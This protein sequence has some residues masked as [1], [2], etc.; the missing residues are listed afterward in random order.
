VDAR[1]V[2]QRAIA[3]AD[4]LGTLAPASPHLVHMPSHTYS[5]VGRYADA[6]RVNEAAVTA[7]LALFEVQKAQGFTV[8]K[9]WRH[10]NQH[11]LWFAALMEGRG[12]VALQAARDIAERAAKSEST[13]G[14]YRRSLP[15][16]ALMRMQRWE[17]VLAE[18]APASRKG[19]QQAL[20]EQARG[21]AYARTGRLAQAR[22]A[23]AQVEAGGATLA[24][25]HAS[26]NRF[27]VM[28][29]EVA[30]SA[31]DHLRAEIASAEGR[32]DEALKLQARA[33]AAS[34]KADD[35]EPPMLAAGAR[36]ALG[37]LQLRAGRAALAEATYR[38]DL[39]AQP[40]SG[41]AL[42]GL[43]RALQAQGKTAEAD[44]LKP[45]LEAAW[46]LADAGLKAAR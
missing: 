2:A 40:G 22:T 33:L 37:D 23:L 24:K 15:V 3:A 17:A 30:Q 18:P 32:H 34:A 8:S 5:Q 6:T 7:E 43:T 14:E 26:A 41:W 16:L 31:A 45:Q 28:L 36:V 39:A 35:N 20:T 25:A 42:N 10:H 19:L 12:D 9:D 29:R 27:D 11:F 4:R 21:V 1:G 46:A 13:F 38:E 44:R